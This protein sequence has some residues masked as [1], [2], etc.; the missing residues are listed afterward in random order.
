MINHVYFRSELNSPN[1]F[2]SLQ[3]SNNNLQVIRNVIVVSFILSWYLLIYANFYRLVVFLLQIFFDF[4]D[5]ADGTVSAP[6]P[7]PVII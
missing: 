3:L 7:L 4:G 6:L 1:D 2:H 5:D